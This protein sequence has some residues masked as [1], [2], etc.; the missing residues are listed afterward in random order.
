MTALNA[1]VHSIGEEGCK[2]LIVDNLVPDARPLVDLAA[3]MAPFPKPDGILY[4]GLRRYIGERDR[5]AAAYA[6]YVCRALAPLLSD[7]FGI[8]GFRID[9]ASFSLATRRP[10][11]AAPYMRIPHYDG[12]DQK[13][14]AVLHYLS[15]SPQGGTAFYRHRRTGFEC[16]SPDRAAAYQAGALQDFE[17]YGEPQDYIG[18]S[19]QAFERI[20]DV[21]AVFNRCLIYSGAMLH[22][23]QLTGSANFSPDPRQGRL[24][25]NIFIRVDE[26][27]LGPYKAI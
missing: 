18:A 11:E 2:I 4:P 19:T 21:E 26:A 10:E 16:I 27:D 6:A 13:A 25:G 9:N 17:D 1:Q 15:E 3:R 14:F 24:T 20:F 8:G 7:T 12:I 23:G 22:S 5:E